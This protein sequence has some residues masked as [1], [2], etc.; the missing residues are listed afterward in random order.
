[1]FLSE[2]REFPS[3]SFLAAKKLDILRLDEVEIACVA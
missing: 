1:M 2:L 3:V